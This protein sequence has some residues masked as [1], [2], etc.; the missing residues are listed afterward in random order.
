MTIIQDNNAD[1][2]EAIIPRKL[3][4]RDGRYEEIAVS[5]SIN[6][7]AQHVGVNI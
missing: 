7:G 6:H 1:Q 2:A 5:S 4:H 3:E